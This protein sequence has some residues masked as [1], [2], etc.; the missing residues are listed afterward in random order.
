MSEI[1]R[2]E[3]GV[4]LIGTKFMGRAHSHAYSTV[5]NIFPDCPR[6]RMRVIC[7]RDRAAAE[8]MAARFG[9]ESIETDWQRVLERKDIDVVDI[10]T[11]GYL[12]KEM[13]VAAAQAG[14]H[15][16]CEKPLG[17]SGAEAREM[18]DAV[19][20]AKGVN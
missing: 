8:S 16:L 6:P 7:G 18:L 17:N 1:K 11:P 20:R 13:A 10:C 5:A 3:I 12:H 9:W 14:K 15:V 2:P 4:A 19:T